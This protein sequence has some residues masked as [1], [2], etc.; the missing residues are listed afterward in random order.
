[1]SSIRRALAITTVERYFAFALQVATTVVVSRLLTPAEIGVWGIALAAVMLLLGVREF[2]SETFLIQRPNLTPE[3]TQSA[4]S[5][6]L[7]AVLLIF[8]VLNLLGPLFADFYREQGLASILRVFSVAL[9]VEALGAPLVALMRR[10]M[11]FGDVA[12]VN[13][14]RSVTTATVTIGLAAFGFSYMSFAW[15]WLAAAVLCSAVSIYLRPDL[16][17]YKPRLDGWR[18]VLTFG[19]YNGANLVLY[20]VYE[21]LPAFLLGRTLS[22]D[23]VGIYNRAMLVCQL[24]NNILLGAVG[25]VILPALSAEVRAGSDLRDSYLRAASLITALLWPA[26]VVLAVL[27]QGLVSILLGGQWLQAVPLIQ[28]MAIAALPSFLMELTFPVLVAVGAMRDLLLRALVAW[29]LSA[30]AIGA[31][32]QFGLTAIALSFLVIFPMQAWVSL[33]FVRRHVDV[34]WR[35]LGQA[36][37]KSAVVSAASGAGPLAVMAWWGFHVHVPIPVALV[38]VM[39]AA[40]GWLAGLRFTRHELLDEIAGARNLGKRLGM[41]GGNRGR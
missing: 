26:L 36:C 3:E 13:I 15:G 16:W 14:T 18:A 21:T 35:D 39:L 4:F 17:V 11:A 19:W 25:P 24:P 30:L 20:R 7:I 29:P 27:A 40:T 28:I 10:D 22:L 37:W 6:I 8:S 32:A 9:L 12:I 5:V 2:A 38:A 31:A 34:G 33:Q 1:M 41:N 23:A